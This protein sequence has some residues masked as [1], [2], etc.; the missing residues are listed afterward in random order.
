V[1]RNEIAASLAYRAAIKI[2]ST[3]NGKDEMVDRSAA[4][5]LVAHHLPSWPARDSQAFKARY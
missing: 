2:N 4:S 5:D 3:V 1:I